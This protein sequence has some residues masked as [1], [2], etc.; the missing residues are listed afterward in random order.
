[1]IPAAVQ[2]YA[3]NLGRRFLQLGQR[4]IQFGEL[5]D[6]EQRELQGVLTIREH[7][8][9]TPMVVASEGSPADP[10]AL[11][12]ELLDFLEGKLARY[13]R[14]RRVFFWEALPA[15]GYGKIPKHLVR[16]ELHR[17]GDVPKGRTDG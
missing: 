12:R 1:M 7:M 10:A 17:R 11:E 14:P 15:S 9:R 8:K 13:K 3:D 2:G 6:S 5:R 16:E 4:K